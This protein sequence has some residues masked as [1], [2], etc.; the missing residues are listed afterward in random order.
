RAIGILDNLSANLFSTLGKCS[1]TNVTFLFS[2]FSNTCL[3]TSWKCLP[4]FASWKVDEQA[5]H[6][7]A[8]SHLSRRENGYANPLFSVIGKILQKLRRTNRNMTIIVPAWPS[9]FWWPLL[10]ELLIEI[11]LLLPD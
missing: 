2:H 6:V 7:D 8:L 11:P 5:T 4:R 9:Q 1:T 3:A 10:L